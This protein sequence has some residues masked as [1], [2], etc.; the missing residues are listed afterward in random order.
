[1]NPDIMYNEYIV[2]LQLVINNFEYIF[3][4]KVDFTWLC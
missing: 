4:L 2:K 1:M 3:I